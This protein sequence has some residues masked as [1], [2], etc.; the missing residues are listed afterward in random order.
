MA[1]INYAKLFTKRKDGIYQKRVNGKYLYSRDPEELYRKWQDEISG[2]R[3]PTFKEVAEEWEAHHREEVSIRTWNNYR[4][5]FDDIISKFGERPISEISASDVANDLTKAKTLG[6]SLTVAKSRKAIYSM[7]LDYAIAKEYIKYNPAANVRI[8]KGLP[9]GT[10]SAPTDEE[11][12]IIMS[13]I[14][15]PFGFFPFFLVC[16]GLRKAEALALT[17]DDIDLDR[18]KIYVNKAV[19]YIDNSNPSI[20]PPKTE[21]SNREVPIIGILRPELIKYISQLNGCILFPAAKS[22]RNPG[23][24]YMGERGYEVAWKRYC[25]ATGLNLTAHQLRH[26]AAT[27]MFEAGV[28]EH[29]AQ[30]ILGHS[31]IMTTIGIYTDLRDRQQAKSIDKFDEEL[32]KYGRSKNHEL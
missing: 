8:P 25:D 17:T 4:P 1:R 18:N 2:K 30:R 15:A 29:T 16:T 32:S 21:M 19:V 9:H 26:A 14:D 22:N 27:I 3:E 11:I 23:G 20:K 24:G 5:H 10:R 28:D 7:I 6:Y 12:R 13:S 31:N